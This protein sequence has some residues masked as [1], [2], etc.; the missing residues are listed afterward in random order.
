MNSQYI[1]QANCS[2][3]D[4]FRLI[5]NEMQNGTDNHTVGV[6][7]MH[8]EFAKMLANNILQTIEAYEKKVAE[9]KANLGTDKGLN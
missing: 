4:M 5:L 1:N 2:M 3:S 8:L 6:F 9:Q 7:A